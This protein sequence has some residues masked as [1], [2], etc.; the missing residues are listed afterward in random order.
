M[1]EGGECQEKSLLLEDF[2][3]FPFRMVINMSFVIIKNPE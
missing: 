1:F 3:F 2:V